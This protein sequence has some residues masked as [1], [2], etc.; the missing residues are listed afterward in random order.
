MKPLKVI[1]NALR[2]SAK[3]RKALV[4][5]VVALSTFAGASVSP[6]LAEGLTEVALVVGTA[7]TDA[8]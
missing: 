4:L 7:L 1:L 5:A 8:Q 6:D 2:A 3:A